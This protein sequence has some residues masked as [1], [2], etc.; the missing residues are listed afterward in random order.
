MGD[1]FA[2]FC[3]AAAVVGGAYIFIVWG[4]FYTDS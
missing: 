4:E 1:I 2:C 3:V